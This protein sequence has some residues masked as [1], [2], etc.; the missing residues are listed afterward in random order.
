MNLSMRRRREAEEP[1]AVEAVEPVEPVELVD[2]V[3][4]DST[5]VRALRAQIRVLEEALEV[6]PDVPAPRGDE[7]AYR[8]RVR[9]AVQAVTARAHEH[10]DPRHMAARVAAAIE[11][12]DVEGFVRPVLPG[13]ATTRAIAAPPRRSAI[14]PA[15]AASEVPVLDVEPGDEVVLPV[16]PPAREEPRR[17][18]R[19]QRQHTAA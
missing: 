16:P 12:L 6:A 11:R 18:K 4:E 15:P 14:A 9:I 1:E 3:A 5:T 10:D 7:A 2:D 13:M 8:R 19:R 17:S